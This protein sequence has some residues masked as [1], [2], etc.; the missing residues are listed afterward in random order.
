MTATHYEEC[1]C[2][3]REDVINAIKS[4][5]GDYWLC[6]K[7][8]Y[9]QDNLIDEVDKAREDKRNAEE[10]HHRIVKENERL[11]AKYNREKEHHLSLM[12]FIGAVESELGLGE[13]RCY[14]YCVVCHCSP[15]AAQHL[16]GNHAYQDPRV[17][18]K[19]K[20]LKAEKAKLEKRL[21]DV[22]KRLEDVK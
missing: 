15:N 20:W 4:I 3:G 2:C 12:K 21:E 14:H 7:C 17:L 18:E 8:Y 1:C 9:D 11:K 19:I 10:M 16:L 13:P 5:V 6:S 22:K